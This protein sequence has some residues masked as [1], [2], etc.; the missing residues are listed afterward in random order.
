VAKRFQAPL[1]LRLKDEDAERVR[2]NHEQRIRELQAV[3][4][5]GGRIATDIDLPDGENVPISHGLG[6][7]A[8]VFISPAQFSGSATTGRIREVR[9]PSFDPTQY[10]VLRASGW[11][12]TITVD[13][14]L[15]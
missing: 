11:S 6:R 8:A 14:W 4:I 5:V 9:D 3:P 13:A 7:K 2:R 1:A 12:E 15:F 10:V